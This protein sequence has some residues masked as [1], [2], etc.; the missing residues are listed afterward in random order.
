MVKVYTKTGDDGTTGLLYGGRV[1]KD[2]HAMQ[3][4]GA[5]DEAQASM[6]VARAE[7]APGSELDEL[8]VRLERDLYV[9]MA[10][11]A[12]NPSKRGQRAPGATL[13]TPAMVDALEE[14]IDGL[15]AAVELPDEF[16]VPG[17]NRAS[18]A[19]DVARTVVRRAERLAVSEPVEG[20]SVGRYLNRLSDLRWV[21]ARWAEGEEHLLARDDRPRGGGARRRAAGG[22]DIGADGGAD[23]ATGGGVDREHGA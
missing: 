13:V 9:L 21:M 10:V 1:R 22:A 11:V 5:V 14:R 15:L 3:V 17:A 19:L 20:S 12:T 18:A 8:L 6:G 4:N 7:A 16:I 23:G 2:A